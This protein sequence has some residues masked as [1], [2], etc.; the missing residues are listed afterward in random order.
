LRRP[1][2]GALALF[3][4]AAGDW[5]FHAGSG[6]DVDRAQTHTMG[7]ADVHIAVLASGI[8]WDDP[9]LAERTALNAGELD[10]DA[11][12][13]NAK[14]DACSSADCNND[15]LLTL[16]DYK[17]DPR[18]AP[19]VPDECYVGGDQTKKQPT[20]MA[21]D[22][23]RNCVFDP[24]D[25][26]L[27]FSDGV[28]DD[29]NGYTDDIAGWDF[30][31]NDNDPAD[32]VRA[33]VGT[34]QAKD[35]LG[36]CP[37]CRIVPIRVA[38]E[39]VGD[40]NDVAQGLIYAADYGV[41]VASTGVFT[42][43]QTVF[44]KAAFDYAYAKGAVVVTGIGDADSRRHTM[45]ATANHVL[46]VAGVRYDGDDPTKATSFL[47]ADGCSNSGAAVAFSAATLG[48]S[49]EAAAVTAGIGGLL[50]S[51][52]ADAKLTL[53]AEEAMQLLR[54]SVDD[55]GV[56][57]FDP[58]F[59]SGRLNA[60][61]LIDAVL[62]ARIPP[63]VDLTGPDWFAPIHANRVT[64]P[65]QIMGRIAASRAKTYDVSVQY[66]AGVQPKDDDYR[67]IVPIR[68]GIPATTVTGGATPIAQLDPAQIDTAQ[69]PD[70]S[71]T[72][73]VRATAHQDG[74][75]DLVGEARRV[76][77]VT[78]QKNGLDPDLVAGFPLALGASIESSPKL[79]DIDGDGVRD[80][81]VADSAGRLHV[82]VQ[83]DGKPGEATGFPYS[84][85]I[86]DGLNKNLTSE[87]TVPSY[88]NAAAYTGG[89]LTVDPTI[90]REAIVAA[91]AI[92]DLDGDGQPEIV[93]T[94]WAGT[95]YVIN[96]KG[97]DAPGW[98]KRL[99]LVPSA[100]LQHQRTRGTAS[101]PVLAD[102]DGDGKLEI[103]ITAFDGQLW[104]FDTGGNVRPNFPVQLSD[105]HLVATPA[106]VDLDGDGHPELI[107]GGGPI[108]A[109]DG[110]GKAI[111]GWPIDI[112]R[113][114]L[115]PF[116]GEA[117]V[118]APV[119]ADFDGD[120]R[121]DVVLLGD[122]KTPQLV[123][124][125]NAAPLALVT[126]FG[127]FFASPAIG[128]VD[129]DGVPDVV[130]SGGAPSLANV[131]AGSTGTAR[132]AASH[133]VAIWS[134]KTGTIL[135]SITTEDYAYLGDHT[136]ADVS[137][138]EY[139]E[140]ITGTGGYLLHAADGCGR[141]APGFPKA[142]NGWIAGTAAVGD[143]DGDLGQH[144]EIVAGTR[145]GYLFAWSTK[146]TATG[147]VLWES[148]H[149]DNANTGWTATPLAQGNHERAIAPLSCAGGANAKPARFDFEGGCNSTNQR[150]F[151]LTA[152]LGLVAMVA[153]RRRRP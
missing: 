4:L 142:T 2:V 149:H 112:P 20:R 5:S 119:A 15:G 17:D 10:D 9:A 57:G 143:I 13:K 121:P 75:P 14:G 146:G 145:E 42:V 24:G 51:A 66:A 28:D 133:S 89:Q 107:A 69:D 37:N 84:T 23:N 152:L 29:A 54:G 85:R 63:E 90:A 52:A 83:R 140:I 104:T 82:F 134:G 70:R 123:A 43:D 88:S 76:I 73:R 151:S 98:P 150:G 111:V 31:T 91:P 120:G 109:V 105:S 53:S 32:D 129:Q 118:A 137:G 30:L 128:D 50:F 26:V 92:A 96:D 22:L 16:A 95:I 41:K 25:L 106:A 34:T 136:I 40:A 114:P 38:E 147:K 74:L 77:A 7:R 27:L 125:A 65:I 144:V 79:A 153:L 18:V 101:A 81:V 59:G 122:A 6:M 35:I 64:G 131:F 11:L 148:F 45:P 36:L 3:C 139:P 47:Q 108:S 99:P 61:V 48:C 19:F 102:L 62:A 1:F 39:Y 126:T 56:P 113:Q 135:G 110:T 33:G 86:T 67:D 103:A 72:I 8:A 138:D 116:V 132:P 71:I 117:V 87:V 100:D 127:A 94:T 78:N 141:E 49:R 58:Q 130:V 115:V 46:P 80:I 97:Q 68:T 21:G 44:S 55:A 60:G 124:S 12:P 93:F